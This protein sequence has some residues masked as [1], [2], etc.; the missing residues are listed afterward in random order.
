MKVCLSLFGGSCND[1][2]RQLQAFSSATVK[3]MNHSLTNQQHK[4]KI[5]NVIHLV[6]QRYRKWH[7]N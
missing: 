4:H 7:Q 3:A 1:R 5:G 6:L 2:A